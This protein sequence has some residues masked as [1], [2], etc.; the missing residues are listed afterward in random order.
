MEDLIDTL[1]EYFKL[2]KYLCKDCFIKI[3][4][5]EDYKLVVY[6]FE[7]KKKIILDKNIYLTLKTKDKLEIIK[8]I[9]IKL[10]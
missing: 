5:I 8:D 6:C 10:S 2:K 9:I 1:N 3:F 7:E 4:R